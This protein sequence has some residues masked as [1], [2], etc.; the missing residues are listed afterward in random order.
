[1]NP[2]TTNVGL[3]IQAA[4]VRAEQHERLSTRR[5][6][7]RF[8]MR[9]DGGCQALWIR[10]TI[11]ARSGDELDAQDERCERFVPWERLDE[12]ACDLVSIVDAC[13]AAADAAVGLRATA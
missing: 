13:V 6:R 3:A 7:V 1:M 11:A 2:Q 9:W 12:C 5:L 4:I 10:A 8:A